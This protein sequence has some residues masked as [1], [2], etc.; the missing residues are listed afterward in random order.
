MEGGGGGGGRF[1][2]LHA[3]REIYSNKLNARKFNSIR[4]YRNVIVA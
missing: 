2:L 4:F 3:G 1:A